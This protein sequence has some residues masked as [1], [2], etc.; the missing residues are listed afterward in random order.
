MNSQSA[1]SFGNSV[2]KHDG[3][4]KKKRREEKVTKNK[5]DGKN[6]EFLMRG[7]RNKNEINKENGRKKMIASA[8]TKPM[9]ST[10]FCWN[11]RR[12][13]RKAAKKIKNI[14]RLYIYILLYEYK[15]P[16]EYVGE[17]G[18]T[19]GMIYIYM[20]TCVTYSCYMYYNKQH[21]ESIK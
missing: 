11:R 1:R 19:P 7:K 5:K 9:I 18:M 15:L 6:G 4:K 17:T 2:L 16:G 10:R 14:L 20:I 12:E 8:S 13:T 21:S 3:R